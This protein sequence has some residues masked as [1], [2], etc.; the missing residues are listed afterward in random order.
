MERVLIILVDQCSRVYSILWKISSKIFYPPFMCTVCDF[1]TVYFKN[2][3]DLN[4]HTKL[5]HSIKCDFCKAHKIR[6]QLALKKHMKQFHSVKCKL[7]GAEN[8]KSKSDL[9]KHVKSSCYKCQYCFV[10]YVNAENTLQKHIELFHNIE[11][12]YHV[13]K[14]IGHGKFGEVHLAKRLNDCESVAIK[15]EP[16]NVTKNHKR[17]KNEFEFYKLL[18]K[19]KGIPEVYMF[20]IFKEYNA[21]VM[22]LLGPS[23]YDLLEEHRH[24]FTVHTVFQIAIQLIDTFEYIHSKHLI[25]RDISPKNILIG[26]YSTNKKKVIYVV[27]LGLSKKYIDSITGE[28]IPYK[29]SSGTG[30]GTPYFMSINA[31]T[32]K[33][34][35]RRDDLESLGYLIV[36]FMRGML[37]WPKKGSDTITMWKKKI[38]FMKQNISNEKLCEDCSKEFQKTMSSYFNHVKSIGF[39]ESP[40]YS[41]LQQL[42]SHVFDDG[43]LDDENFEFVWSL[44]N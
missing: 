7:C 33:E 42:F 28:H 43:F 12:N 40:N 4:R 10:Q 25:H 32:G 19:H 20:D 16:L 15:M 18:G 23:M 38:C 26:P 1:E 35:S 39:D 11:S 17:L 34:L 44:N 6:S 36:Y 14:K 29:K 27:D 37:P 3:K 2:K 41:Y 30:P 9:H 24:K 5:C 21:L 13:G 31:H 8:L 22:E